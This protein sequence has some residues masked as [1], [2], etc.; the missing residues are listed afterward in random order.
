MC[1]VFAGFLLMFAVG[2]IAVPFQGINAVEQ[3]NYA[4]KPKLDAESLKDGSF[5]TGLE[6][7]LKDRLIF[8]P[9]LVMLRSDLRSIFGRTVPRLV[10]SGKDC[11]LM[12][13]TFYYESELKAAA[14]GGFICDAD[15][16][17]AG[18]LL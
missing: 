16:P 6:D 14:C 12:L 4:E 9:Q 15:G 17:A 10:Y 13:R 5:M 18:R 8:R 1:T 7:Y 2:C 3:R 11:Q